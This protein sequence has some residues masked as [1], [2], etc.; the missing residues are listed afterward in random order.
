MKRLW[1]FKIN[2][3]TFP[4]EVVCITGSCPELGNWKVDQVLPMTAQDDP[5]PG[6]GG[7]VE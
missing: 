3:K 1:N 2:C 6:Y 4:G 5:Y 7:E